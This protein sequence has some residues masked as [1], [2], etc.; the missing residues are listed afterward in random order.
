MTAGIPNPEP[1]S[2]APDKQVPS[3][4]K[5]DFGPNRRGSEA[6]QNGAMRAAG[7]GRRVPTLVLDPL[8]CAVCGY[9]L[10]G[11]RIDK[12]SVTCPECAYAQPLVAWDPELHTGRYRHHPLV[13]LL[14]GFGSLCAIGLAVLIGRAVFG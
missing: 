6:V 10:A 14:A 4:I 11:L 13:L 3:S 8:R 5:A 9:P 2:G 1:V 7:P 12:A